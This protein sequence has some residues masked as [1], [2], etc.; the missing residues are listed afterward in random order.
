MEKNQ[1][2]DENCDPKV[3]TEIHSYEDIKIAKNALLKSLGLPEDMVGIR[4][5]P[6]SNGNIIAVDT[7]QTVLHTLTEDQRKQLANIKELESIEQAQKDRRELAQMEREQAKRDREAE[8]RKTI[9]RNMFAAIFDK[10]MG[11]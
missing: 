7:N 2:I 4:F 11:R 3:L 9:A 6:A 8:K 5:I 1:F 10:L